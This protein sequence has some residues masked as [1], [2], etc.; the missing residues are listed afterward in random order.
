ML[1]NISKKFQKTA[2]KLRVATK[3]K[4]VFSN[5]KPVIIIA[6]AVLLLAIVTI[7]LLYANGLRVQEPVPQVL[8][9][10]DEQGQTVK[11]ETPSPFES[12]DIE[13]AYKKNPDTIGWLTLAG[14]EIDDPVM[15]GLDN[16]AYLRRTEFSESYDEW[17]CYFLDYINV[18]DKRTLPDR[19]SIIYG[20]S[21]DDYSES[22]KFSKLKR[23]KASDFASENL[24]FTFSLLY[25]SHE[26]QIFAVSDVPISIDYIDPNPDD[27][28]YSQ[29]L[30]YL[31]DNSY[32][33]FGV[34]VNTNN[35]ILIL[36][37]CTS[38]ENVRF[39]VAGKLVS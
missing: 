17:G 24:T 38:D 16:S 7:V 10:S 5:K 26:Y 39:V 37:T 15:Q 19:V 29:T 18:N 32:Y 34:S 3:N 28:K 31:L 6:G 8:Q 2:G 14:C 12:E 30:Q 20:H 36:S 21:L 35:Q 1:N 33:N 13:A 25:E 11:E 4:K 9:A 22:K 23:F 27:A